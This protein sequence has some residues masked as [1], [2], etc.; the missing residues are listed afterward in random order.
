MPL[1]HSGVVLIDNETGAT[2]YYEYG[3]YPSNVPGLVGV[4]LPANKGNIRTVPIPD[5]E[6][7]ESGLPTKESLTNIFKQLSAKAGKGNT[8]IAN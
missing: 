2:K 5:V 4:G 1:G 6:I 3:R 8:V 7:S